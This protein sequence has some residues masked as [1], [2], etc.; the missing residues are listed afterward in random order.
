MASSFAAAA[1][2]GLQQGVAD[3]KLALAG[4]CA[5]CP[6]P[7]AEIAAARALVEESLEALKSRVNATGAYRSM[8]ES[9]AECQTSQLL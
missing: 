2:R 5:S 4:W 1:A 6:F 9:G 8:V 3:I 7:H